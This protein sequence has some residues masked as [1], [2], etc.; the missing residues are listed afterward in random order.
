MKC[1]VITSP[2]PVVNETVICNN[3]FANGLE[4]LHLRKPN[5]TAGEYEHFLQQILPQYRNRIVLHDHYELAG[6]YQ[7]HGIHLKSGMAEAYKQYADQRISISCHSIEEIR[8]LPFRAEYCFLSP[9][10]DSISKKDYTTAFPE[11]PDL[12]GI[13]CPVI[14]LGG[15]TPEKTDICRIAGFA[16]TACLG[17]IWEKPEEAISR[18]IRLKTPFVLSIAGLD[19]SGGAGISADIK[20]LYATGSYGLSA[21]TAITFQNEKSYT[22]THWIPLEEITRQC[23]IIF[24]EHQPEYIKIGLIESF[25]ILK[26]LVQWLQGAC[27]HCKIIW[28]PILKASAGHQFHRT[29][30]K[31]LGEIMRNIFLLTPNTEEMHALFGTT[32][33]KEE[34]Q[35]ICKKYGTHILWKGGH[36]EG[37]K[38]TDLLISEKECKAFT[39]LKSRY[40]KHGTGCILS[41]ALA[42]YLAQGETLADACNRAQVYVSQ[43]IESN[44]SLLGFHRNNTKTENCRTLP[45]ELSLQYITAPKAGMTLCEQTEAVCRG[46]M[47]WVQ[48]RMKGA[49]LAEMLETGKLVKEICRRYHCLFIINDQVEAARQLDADGVH[50]GK[51]DMNPLE[52]RAILGSHK[53]IG[54]TCNTWEDILLRNQQG[55]DYIGLGPYTF[56][57][58]KEKLSP[59]LGLS[60]Y[61]RLT[62]QMKAANIHIPVFAI[63]GICEK[64]IPALMQTGIQG[65]A[66]SGLIKN[67][68]DITE[69]TKEIVH[70]LNS[71]S[72][73]K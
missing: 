60:G 49:S 18:F 19:P 30:D 44:E 5:Y 7:V 6:K 21:C 67:S 51:E 38:S 31:E 66:L 39:L 61:Q 42:S 56:T 28:D 58:T 71:L 54:A 43:I 65:I 11:L 41:S 27:P 63:G 16:G 15:I 23:D 29:A 70:L 24:R 13:A 3:L 53:I 68:D 22:G 33:T 59:V 55:V 1:I 72:T 45:R 36:N 35:Q 10:F 48:L 40:K 50:L 34:L 20:T 69:K 26:Q 14:A 25:E 2:T 37:S 8:H 47:R 17:Y 62:E 32:V 57:T 9:I 64:D 4:L 52:A 73:E 12:S 46:G